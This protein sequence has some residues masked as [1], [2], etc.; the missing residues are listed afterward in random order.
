MSKTPNAAFK[1]ESFSIPE[2]SFSQANDEASDIAVEFN[3]KG[4]YTKETQ[5]FELT[6]DF[7]AYEDKAEDPHITSKLIAIFKFEDQLGFDEIPNYF[8]RNSLAILFPYLRAFI[9]NLTIQA[10]LKLIILPTLNLSEL[11]KPLRDNTTEA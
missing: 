6:L 5:S 11:E 2:F 4:I 7:I 9:S 3:P 10:N 8:Y 1:L